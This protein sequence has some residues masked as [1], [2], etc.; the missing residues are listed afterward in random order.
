MGQL[1][2]KSKQNETRRVP[3]RFW[4]MPIVYV[5]STEGGGEREIMRK[6]V[7]VMFTCGIR[8]RTSE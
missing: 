6:P 7:V 8:V 2:Q 5:A 3:S 1:E 4:S